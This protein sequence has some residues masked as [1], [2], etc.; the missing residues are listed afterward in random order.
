MEGMFL[1]LYMATCPATQHFR[2]LLGG[3]QIGSPLEELMSTQPGRKILKLPVNNHDVLS[4]Y[5]GTGH[6]IELIAFMPE[7]AIVLWVGR[8]DTWRREGKK[9]VTRC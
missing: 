8:N 3:T 9:T 1:L 7:S 6:T 2:F 4:K 5:F